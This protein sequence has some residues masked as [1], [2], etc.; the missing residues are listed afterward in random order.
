MNKSPYVLFLGLAFELA[1]LVVA[2]LFLG[3]WFDNK[4]SLGG[5]GIAGGAFLGLGIWVTHL[6]MVMNAA[7][8]LEEEQSAKE[9]KETKLDQ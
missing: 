4:Y 1:G 7:N 5:F 3:Q 9:S 6:I 2:F 8:K